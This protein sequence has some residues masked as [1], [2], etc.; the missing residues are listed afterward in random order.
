MK[1]KLTFALVASLTGT[2]FAGFQAPL[3]EFKNQKELAEWCAEKASKATSQSYAAEESAFY[4]GKPYL[5]LSSGY[6]FKY[7]NYIPALARWTSEDPSGFPDGSNG[8]NY[9]PIPT[10]EYDYQGLM[11]HKA[12]N[13]QTHSITLSVYVYDS[14]NS[15]TNYTMNAWKSVVES[16]WVF[17]GVD[18]SNDQNMSMAV[19]I[20][21]T[22]Q[23]GGTFNSALASTF[24]NYV[25]F[26]KAANL[27]STVYNQS[28]GVWRDNITDAL[29]VHEVGHF[30]KGT[31]QYAT[32]IT[33]GFRNTT[34]YNTE[35]L[36]DWRNSIMGDM[37]MKAIR[38]DANHILQ[39][40]GETNH[41]FE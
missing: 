2:A 30:M 36:G 3:P 21:F 31:D 28:H 37:K 4:T 25:T 27:P 34:P 1:T 7:R 22:L 10:C 19:N 23:M 17:S 38:L 24:D 18:K 8:T 9:T 40:L 14:T 13:N 20:A 16:A 41:L 5:T 33:N 26:T 39:S 15:F 11:A 6:A 12:F 29:V 35:A 32:S